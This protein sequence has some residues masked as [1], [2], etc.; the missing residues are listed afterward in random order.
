MITVT[1]QAACL[2]LCTQRPAA[3]V[4]AVSYDD[5]YQIPCTPMVVQAVIEDCTP[6]GPPYRIP[7]F[8]DPNGYQSTA[9]M[10]VSRGDH[11]EM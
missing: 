9:L 10:A 1:P 6:R 8:D 7:S 4:T 11:Y 2:T 3:V 5:R